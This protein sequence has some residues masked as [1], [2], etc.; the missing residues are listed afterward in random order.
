MFVDV[1]IGQKSTWTTLSS[2]VKL[3]DGFNDSSVMKLF[4]RWKVIG[5]GGEWNKQLSLM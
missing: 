4:G 2:A 3:C 1:S 5:E